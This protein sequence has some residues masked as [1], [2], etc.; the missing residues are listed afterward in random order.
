VTGVAN[1]KAAGGYQQRG[2]HQQGPISNI[3]NKLG[4]YC[5]LK[6]FTGLFAVIFADRSVSFAPTVQDTF[7]F[8]ESPGVA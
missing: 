5:F 1:A 3:T 6:L 2:V 8:V 7:E 4:F